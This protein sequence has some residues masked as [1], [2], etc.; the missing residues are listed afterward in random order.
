MNPQKILGVSNDATKEE[1]NRAYREKVRKHHPDLGGDAWAFQQVQEAYELLINPD[2]KKPP[3]PTSPKQAASPRQAAN[4]A[5][6]DARQNGRPKGPSANASPANASTA[7]SSAINNFAAK[8]RARTSNRPRT[9]AAPP[10]PEHWW[11]LFSH[12]LPLQNETTI[13]ILINVFD[14]FMTYILLRFDAVEANPIANY[15]FKLWNFSGMI[16]FKLVIVALVC[17]I[18]QFVALKKIQSARFLLIIGS[19]LTGTVVVYSMWLLI[20]HIL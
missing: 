3:R 19:V 20:N 14:I 8:Q 16:A 6:A 10:P 18:A 7:K 4:H 11:H 15:F 17:V 9:K 12:Q 13:F 2:L 1:I 5:G